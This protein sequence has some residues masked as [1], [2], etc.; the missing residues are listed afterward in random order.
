MS[1]KPFSRKERLE[2]FQ[3]E[4]LR[5]APRILSAMDRCPVSSSCGCLDRE[6]WAW[7]TKDFANCDAQRGILVLLYVYKNHFNDN[8]YY[9]KQNILNWITWGVEFWI[10]QQ[11]KNGGFDHLYIHEESWM[12]AAFTLCDMIH[13]YSELR[14]EF[15]SDLQE[16]LFAAMIK[17]ADF[18]CLHEENHGF[19]SNHR[20][21][22]AAALAGVYRLSDNNKYLDRAHELMNEVYAQ[23]STE[24]WFSEY[25]GAD[26][27]YQTLDMHYQALYYRYTAEERVLEKVA[28]SLEFLKWF[29]HPD[30]SIGGEYGSRSCPHYFP[31]GFEML[32]GKI[33]LAESIA[34]F[35]T[36]GL[37]SGASSGAGDADIR[38]EIVLA[39]S[40]V[41]AAQA[42]VESTADASDSILLPCQEKFAVKEFPKAGLVALKDDH[43]FAVVGIS[44]GGVYKYFSCEGELLQSSCGYV[45]KCKG[46]DITTNMYCLDPQFAIS[47]D[48][49]DG[50]CEIDF[51]ASFYYYKKNRLA[52]PLLFLG[53]RIFNNTIGRSR[54]L[55]DFVRKNL[56]I[57][58]FLKARKQAPVAMRRRLS[59]TK[60]GIKCEDELIG[61]PVEDLKELSFF[62]TVYMASA[63]Y[64]RRQDLEIVI[65]NKR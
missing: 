62:S 15:S 17:S 12:A 6:Y 24:G 45:A 26:P 51:T 57:G 47:K 50:M 7:A 39:T 34:A 3:K 63:R 30:A 19:I 31:G 20:A 44:K 16:R 4:L 2:Y 9:K 65:D 14:E 55:N 41:Y 53:F 18:L 38:N 37:E 25:G 11:S 56:I 32:A 42:L 59:I 21:G 54:W 60:Q 40:Y 35:C 49:Q 28:S 5:I 43:G 52:S 27:G 13:I 22:A 33:P 58:I 23:Q 29:I 48:D 61:D 8:L 1:V 36:S 64:F 46:K 10:N